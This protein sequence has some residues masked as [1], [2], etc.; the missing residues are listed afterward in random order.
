MERAYDLEF[1]RRL[2]RIRLDYG[3]GGPAGL[4]GG[5][6]L[7][8]DIIS[9]TSDYLEHAQKK[10][11]VRLALSL[12]EEFPSG[13]AAFIRTGLLPF[14]TDLEFFD[15]RYPGT[16]RRKL[17]KIELFVEGLVPLEGASGFLTCHGVCSE[18]RAAARAW[19]KHTR[20]MP[21]ERMVL[22]S[23]QFRRDIAVF[24]PSE[25]LLG[26]FENNRAASGLDRSRSR[27][28]PTISTTTPS[29]TSS[30]SSTSTPTSVTRCPRTSRRSIRTPPAD[31]R[32]C[33][34]AS[35]FPTSIS[36]SM[37]IAVSVSR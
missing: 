4:L 16:Y 7:K 27:A 24:Q 15:R 20:V 22:S 30:S 37:P 19:V 11:P 1:D 35:N 25:E 8:R 18:W 31:R 5:D 14:R 17:K 3:L 23:Y 13:F 34:L 12:R 21:V 33:R 10:N 2:N 26:L 32:W 36:A 6:M 28:R 9:F 29:P